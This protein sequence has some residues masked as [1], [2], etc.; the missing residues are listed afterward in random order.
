MLERKD[1]TDA[2]NSDRIRLDGENSEFIAD[3]AS[4][5]GMLVNRLLWLSVGSPSLDSRRT[6]SYC[7]A[8]LDPIVGLRNNVS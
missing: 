7:P 4:A 1:E 5:I 2:T 8:L 3:C 6:I